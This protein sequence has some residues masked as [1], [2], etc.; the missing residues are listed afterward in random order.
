MSIRD[1]IQR[2]APTGSSQKRDVPDSR[3]GRLLSAAGAVERELWF[4][5]VAAM[6]LDVTLTM[7]GLTIGL[8]E[9]NPVAR[10]ALDTAGILG[11]YALK[12]AAL[13]IG[14]SCRLGLDDRY[15]PI[16]PLGLAIPSMVAVIVNT[17]VIAA[18]TL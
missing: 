9:A 17:T 6:L 5:V 1:I 13:A 2:T 4:T 3:F 14:V 8:V 15:G 18:V 10:Y 12:I 11:L 16:V 7:H